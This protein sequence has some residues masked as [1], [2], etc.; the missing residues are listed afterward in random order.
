MFASDQKLGHY[1]HIPPVHTFWAQ[2]IAAFVA[3]L[4]QTAIFNFQLTFKG[5]CTEDA[6]WR[7]TC[8]GTNTFFTAAVFWGT[9]GPTRIFGPGS[10]Y[11]LL[12][13]GFPIGLVVP[14]I[15]W[16]LRKRWPRSGWLRKLHPVMIFTGGIV[17]CPYPVSM[18]LSF[19]YTNLFSWGWLRHRYPRF[20]ERYNFV[21][22]A[23]FSVAIA[24]A[25]IIIFFGLQITEVDINWWGNT[26]PGAG[27]LGAPM[28]W[29][30]LGDG[31]YFG[32]APG[33]FV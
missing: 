24:I 5:V 14:F 1:A 31:E 22:E 18:F 12:L 30:T 4:I 6:A 29:K 25:A 10:R 15:I 8:P 33:T 3:V 26:S 20:W 23:S 19:M 17:S 2:I 7:M 16:G 9:V 28:G 11:K 27:Q 21:L 13:L 32:P